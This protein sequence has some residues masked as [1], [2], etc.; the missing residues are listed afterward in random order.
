M[1]VAAGPYNKLIPFI[2][3]EE[4]QLSSLR[5]EDNLKV[6]VRLSNEIARLSKKTIQFG[7]FAYLTNSREEAMELCTNVEF[8]MEV[9]KTSKDSNV[10][11]LGLS[12]KD[13]KKKPVTVGQRSSRSRVHSYSHTMDLVTNN[14][15]ELHL[16][17]ASFR[18]YKNRISVG[19]VTRETLL[20]KGTAPSTST[21][22][23]LEESVTG[24]GLEGTIWPGAVHRMGNKIMAGNMH[25]RVKHPTLQSQRVPNIKIKDTRILAEAASR[26]PEYTPVD[27]TTPYISPLEV[28]RNTLGI[29]NGLFSFDLARY[30]QVNSALSGIMTNKASLLNSIELKDITIWKKKSGKTFKGNSLT[31]VAKVSCGINNVEGFKQIASLSEGCEVLDTDNNGNEIIDVSYVDD[32]CTGVS[33]GFIEY[34]TEIILADRATDTIAG[35]SRE[36]TGYVSRVQDSLAVDVPSRASYYVPEMMINLYLDALEYLF[37][38]ETFEPYT[39][40]YW[41]SSLIAM[42]YNLQN[43]ITQKQAVL[44]VVEI[45]VKSLNALVQKAGVSTPGP[46]SRRSSIAMSKKEPLLAFRHHFDNKLV[47]QGGANVGLGYVDDVITDLDAVVPKISFDNYNS[48]TTEEATK[49][50]IADPQAKNINKFGFL[51]PAF[52]GLGAKKTV[53]TRALQ[54]SVESFLPLA[55]SRMS[56]NPVQNNKPKNDD[57]LNKLEILQSQGVSITALKVSLKKEVAAP[58]L[59]NAPGISAGAI[60]G[61]TSKFYI[62][63]LKANSVSGSQ[64]S[65]VRMTNRKG[66]TKSPLISQMV[67]KAITNYKPQKTVKNGDLLKGSIALAKTV[68][69]PTIVDQSDSMTAVTNYGSVAQIQ[70][71]APY[72]EGE[73]IKKQNWKLLDKATFDNAKKENKALV[74]RT[75]KVSNTVDGGSAVELNPLSSLFTLGD[76]NIKNTRTIPPT[77]IPTRKS[78]AKTTAFLIEQLGEEMLYSKNVSLPA[79]PRPKKRSKNKKEQTAK[80][81]ENKV[82]KSSSNKSKK[83][84]TGAM[85]KGRSKGNLGY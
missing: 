59:A 38:V 6:V 61:R 40:T 13:F 31:P 52:M 18:S 83:M 77:K 80:T 55:S 69:D 76:V 28:S 78:R 5:A 47:I 24:Y 32:T 4:I 2:N 35:M 68:E 74:C 75:V 82:N 49:Y 42:S 48:R 54:M 36:L 67:N 15:K 20:T 1:S 10:K 34:K 79:P 84:K 21:I 3:A 81:M 27:T 16:V 17:I 7:N 30:I 58:S 43:D 56:L 57:A 62:D 33:S 22:Y 53:E 29:I 64:R 45:F 37:G 73:G 9:I 44:R 72:K 39:R 26:L 71:L 65:I 50:N 46:V 70:Y 41:Q 11:M 60:L 63:N 66:I 12:T 19:N 85:R 14:Q 8:L 51:S 25:V 23:R